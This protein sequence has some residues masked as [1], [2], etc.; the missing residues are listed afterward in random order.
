IAFAGAPAVKR[1]L[2][3]RALLGTVDALSVYLHPLSDIGQSLVDGV[4]KSAELGRTYIQ[5]EVAALMGDIAKLVD[6]VFGRFPVVIA[7]RVAPGVIHGHAGLPEPAARHGV[8]GNSLL[9]SG[10]ILGL[11]V[12]IVDD[13]AGLK[14]AD[15]GVDFCGMKLVGVVLPAAVEP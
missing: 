12:A 11:L 9:G 6:Q 14:L 10:V 2:L 8:G 4:G 3:E 13:D 15:E 5:E 7:F 1:E